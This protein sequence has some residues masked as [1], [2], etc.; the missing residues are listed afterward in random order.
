[1]EWVGVSFAVMSDVY[2]LQCLWAKGQISIWHICLILKLVLYKYHI[3]IIVIMVIVIVII[4]VLIIIIRI[5]NIVIII[6]KASSIDGSMMGFFL[7]L[8]SKKYEQIVELSVIWDAMTPM[9]RHC[10]D[11]FPN[12]YSTFIVRTKQVL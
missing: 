12:S 9:W 6:I 11:V 4:I 8:V 10:S 5:V 7:S 3:I 2:S 1:M